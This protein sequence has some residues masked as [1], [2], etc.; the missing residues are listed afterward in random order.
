[1]GFEDLKYHLS[2]QID[3]V[4]IFVTVLFLTTSF[5]HTDAQKIKEHRELT[6]EEVYVP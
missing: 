3:I 5:T 2:R 6:V 4:R 1:M